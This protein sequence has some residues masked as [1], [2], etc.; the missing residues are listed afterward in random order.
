MLILVPT[1]IFF[2]ESSHAYDYSGSYVY[3]EVNITFLDDLIKS[4]QLF[5]RI[6][7]GC[8]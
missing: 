5:C 1:L 7:Q 8:S 2:W 3:S 6:L 4:P